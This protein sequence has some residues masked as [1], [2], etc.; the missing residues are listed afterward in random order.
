MR[1]MV[2]GLGDKFFQLV[3]RNHFPA[4]DSIAVLFAN[5]NP[6]IR[7]ENYSGSN[8][9]NGKGFSLVSVPQRIQFEV[10][11]RYQ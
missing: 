4:M 2:S 8:R 3:A 6:M 1:R 11:A 10:N 5:F 9:S 7:D